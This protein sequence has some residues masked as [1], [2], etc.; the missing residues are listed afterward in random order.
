MST[1]KQFFDLSSP[2][3]HRYPGEG[4][5]RL[6]GL[7]I[8]VEGVPAGESNCPEGWDL[9]ED[10]SLRYNGAEYVSRPTALSDVPEAL[11]R[12]YNAMPASHTFS[13][14]T[15]THVH[16]NAQDLTF[17]QV[18]AVTLLY[19][20]VEPFM[21]EYVGRN[22]QYN[23]F[24]VPLNCSLS[25][26]MGST[27]AE[28][29]SQF[30]RPVPWSKYLGYNMA[31]LNTHGTL[32][33]RQMTGTNDLERLVTWVNMCHTVVETGRSLGISG[34]TMALEKIVTVQDWMTFV[35][36]LFGAQ[37]LKCGNSQI[38]RAILMT[39]GRMLPN[40]ILPS[41]G[42]IQIHD[43]INSFGGTL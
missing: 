22:R 25:G 31:S 41:L 17:D 32:E 12:L 15:S 10:G 29:S 14:R 38:E 21:Y 27:L 1:V 34:L 18:W 43:F 37:P 19:G 33:F 11:Q 20:L 35:Q 42:T 24:C 13:M 5:G 7:E 39:K 23:I 2:R 26:E 28:A 40:P 8:E 6:T 36:N 30:S 16:V 4:V 3:P 9:T